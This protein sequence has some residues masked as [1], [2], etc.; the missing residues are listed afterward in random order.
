ME[1]MVRRVHAVFTELGILGEQH[2]LGAMTLL[3]SMPGAC[4]QDFHCDFPWNHRVFS[5]KSLEKDD[6]V[7]Y[8]V[9]VLIAFHKEGARRFL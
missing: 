6:T 2:E 9:S 8:S 5:R 1:D 4:Q 3:L 7:P